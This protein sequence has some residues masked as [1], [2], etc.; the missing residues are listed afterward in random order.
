MLAL[1]RSYTNLW[2]M[3]WNRIQKMYVVL[4]LFKR[5]RWQR[6]MYILQY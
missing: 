1:Y 2:Q 4:W 3:Q 6:Q 5:W